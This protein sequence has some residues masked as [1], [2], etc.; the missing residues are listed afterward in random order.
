MSSGFFQDLTGKRFGR[1]LVLRR[2]PNYVHGNASVVQWECRCDCGKDT[3]VRRSCLAT[4]N[5]KSCGC[6]MRGAGRSNRLWRGF[7]D[8]PG[9]YWC[10]VRNSA[11]H[12][13]LVFEVTIEEAW[14]KFQAQDGKCAL[15]GLSLKFTTNST[16]SRSDTTASLDRIDSDLGYVPGNIQWIHKRLQ[17]VKGGM[18]QAEFLLWCKLVAANQ[19]A[20]RSSCVHDN[21]KEVGI[22]F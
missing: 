7:G 13:K 17:G 6:L 5:T 4:G 12:R 19:E 10:Q 9:T 15:S 3:T 22:L 2:G 14:T 16:A 18:P 8:I 20:A 11:K 21:I 1:L